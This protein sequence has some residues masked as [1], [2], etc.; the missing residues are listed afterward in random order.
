MQ[1][2]YY[3]NHTNGGT[4]PA[5]QPSKLSVNAT[6]ATKG[7]IQSKSFV[8]LQAKSPGQQKSPIGQCLRK[9]LS[10]KVESPKF[11]GGKVVNVAREPLVSTINLNNLL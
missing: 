9:A 1:Q 6:L 11:G 8:E 7:L 10:K 5:P 4:D 3:N 2:K